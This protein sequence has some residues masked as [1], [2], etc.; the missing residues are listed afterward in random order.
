[1]TKKIKIIDIFYGKYD[2]LPKKVKA[3]D[4]IWIYDEIAGCHKNK[5]CVR[6]YKRL[7]EFYTLSDWLNF[8]VEILD[9]EEKEDSFTGIKFFQDGECVMS[10]A[11]EP[12]IPVEDEFED[13]EEIEHE[14]IYGLNEN[15]EKIDDRVSRFEDKINALIK[16]QK[17][18][19]EKLKEE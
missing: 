2:K 10:V 12:L 14:Y 9:E 19:I 7:D 16:N 13:I 15:E 3:L 8:E 1:M 17:K 18:I 4:E 11:N 6:L 5:D